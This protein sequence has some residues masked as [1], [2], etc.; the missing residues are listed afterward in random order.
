[1]FCNFYLAINYKT[2]NNS[3]TTKAREG[4]SADLKSLN[5][6][7]KFDACLPKLKNNQK[8]CIPC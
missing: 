1:M 3:T 5:L 8:F 7:K 6:R 2:D 4:I